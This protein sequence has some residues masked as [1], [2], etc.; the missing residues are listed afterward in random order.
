MFYYCV[1]AARWAHSF[2]SYGIISF[3][4]VTQCTSRCEYNFLL[5]YRKYLVGEV[6][7]IVCVCV[8][9]LFSLV[10]III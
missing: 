3:Q 10:S 7:V 9:G 6:C 1:V 8:V 4:I 2:N 5:W